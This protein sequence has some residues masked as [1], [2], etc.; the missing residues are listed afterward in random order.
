MGMLL[1]VSKV[2]VTVGLEYLFKKLNMYGVRGNAYGWIK[3]YLT[4]GTRR[5]MISDNYT[6]AKNHQI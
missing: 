4:K 3:S 1:D 6:N 5:V 2:Y